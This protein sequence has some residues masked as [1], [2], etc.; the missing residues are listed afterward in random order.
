M[1]GISGKSNVNGRRLAKAHR[2]NS[3]AFQLVKR[4]FSPDGQPCGFLV[5]NSWIAA[6]GRDL[7]RISPIPRSKP[8]IARATDVH[9]TAS[10]HQPSILARRRPSQF[11]SQLFLI[12]TLSTRA[13]VGTLMSLT[14]P[15]GSVRK[16]L[17]PVCNGCSSSRCLRGE[18]R[19]ECRGKRASRQS[20]VFAG[21]GR[22]GAT[23]GVCAA[24]RAVQSPARQAD[25]L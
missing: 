22:D 11:L 10:K 4:L 17:H 15:S 16:R 20:E 2:H 23:L 3:S 13:S 25:A 8:R 19:G 12:A 24:T 9:D 21:N 6:D 18:R 7:L 1:Q 14:F 5:R